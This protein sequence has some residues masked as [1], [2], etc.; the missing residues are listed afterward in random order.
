MIQEV[1]KW[2]VVINLEASNQTMSF[3]IYDNFYNN[4]LRKLA[5][6]G[7]EFDVKDINIA[8]LVNIQTDYQANQ[9]SSFLKSK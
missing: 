2:R 9:H 1:Q 6:I 8:K 5:D 4:V 7:F 3:L